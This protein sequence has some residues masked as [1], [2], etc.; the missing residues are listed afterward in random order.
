MEQD[1]PVINSGIFATTFPCKFSH[2]YELVVEMAAFTL[3]FWLCVSFV[4]ISQRGGMQNS[5]PPLGLVDVSFQA[6]DRKREGPVPSYIGAGLL[7]S[8]TLLLPNE[9]VEFMLCRVQT[10]VSAFS[11]RGGGWALQTKGNREI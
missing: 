8:V 10:L 5:L 2:G 3:S 11:H 6:K 9:G 7:T 4:D 1:R